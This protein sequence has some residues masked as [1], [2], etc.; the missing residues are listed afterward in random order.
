VEDG[1]QLSRVTNYLR[2]FIG[3]RLAF[4]EHSR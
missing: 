1:N 3:S 4:I 2:P